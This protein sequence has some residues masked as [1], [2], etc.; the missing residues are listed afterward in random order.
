MQ[1]FFNLIV[2]FFG[3]QTFV[4]GDL[5]VVLLLTILEGLLSIDNALVLGLLAKRSLLNIAG[6]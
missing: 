3:S 2:E 5:A 6:G 4:T 1:A